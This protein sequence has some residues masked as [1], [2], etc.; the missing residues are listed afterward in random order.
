[1]ENMYILDAS[2]YLYRSYFAIR[3]MTNAKGESTN[4]LFGFIRSVLKLIKEFQP[5]HFVAVFDGPRN[6][7]KRTAIYADYKAHRREMP[8]DLYYQ[9]L[10]AQEFCQLMGIPEL[11]IPEVE[12]DDTMGSVAQW[13]TTIGAKSYLCTTDKDMCQLVNENVWMLNSFKDNQLL[14][15][16]GVY[17]QFGV[18]PH[19]MIDFLAITGDAS[20][21]VP[22]LTGF[23]PKTAAD[24]LQKFET[25]DQI[26]EQP[27]LVSGKKKQE[28]LINEREKVLLSR[29]LVTIDTS[30]PFPQDELFFR[31]KPPSFDALKE[32]YSKMNFSSLLRELDSSVQATSP[33]KPTPLQGEVNYHLVDDEAS[34]DQLIVLLSQQK[35]ICL[36]TETTNIHPLKARLVGVGLGIKSQEAWYIP[37]NGQLGMER[38]IQALK[39]L[40]ENPHIGYYG[41]HFK[42]DFHV[43]MNHDIEIKNICFDTML[44]SYLLNSHSRQ[45]SLD[46][47]SLELFDKVKTPIQELIGKGKS[48]ITMDLVPIQQVSDYCCEDVDYTVRLKETLEPLL[49]E[50]GLT[51]LLKD[52]EL[53]LLPVLA[54]MERHGIYVD[55]DYLQKLAVDLTIDVKALADEIYASVGEEFNLNSP[56]QLSQILFEKLAIRPP[57]KTATGHSTSAEVLE[58]LK[59]EYPIAAKILDYRS[60]EK[61][62]STYAES[63][64]ADVHPQTHRIHCNFNQSVTATGR[65]SCQDPNLQ[66]IP[67]RT[68]VGRKIRAAFKPQYPGWS[69]LAADYSQIELRLLAHLSE[70]PMLMTAFHSNEDVHTFT[71]AQIFNIPLAEVTREQRY[72]AKTVNFG[73]MYGQGA[74]GLAQLLSIDVKTASSFIQK[75]FQRYHKVKEFL[76][77]CK[78]LTRQTGKAVTLSGR[79]RLIPEIR[80]QNAGIRA[81]AERFAINAPIQG[82][83]A[84]LIK[85]AM[86]TIDRQLKERQKKAWLILQIHDELLFEVPD[87]ELDE[88]KELV[89][90]AMVGVIQLKVPLIVD[91]NI[92]KNWQEC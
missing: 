58:A 62:R 35:E 49:H 18:Y 19:Q 77:Q 63:L 57:K 79:E 36:D 48:Q 13:A 25:L 51:H 53:P 5:S 27:L 1:M 20:D 21:N 74:F 9:I 10:W 44:A 69:Y 22:G 66:N 37:T 56:K 42:Y 59:F 46:H 83:Q 39:P 52:L 34:L 92:G 7:I 38:V 28:T 50:R 82:T 86:L 78:E 30:V 81:A 31:L 80:S 84:D 16:Q 88:V 11:M 45:H 15:R 8:K 89:H 24:L 71:A 70:D 54:R 29:K 85:M 12:A 68:E 55:V 76:D 60:L 61:L 14:D 91:I 41:H 4:A 67:V 40:L 75:Y 64:P 32:F 6:A 90:E 23:G 17:H 73:T 43:L 2:G 47:L 65:L 72:Q 3:Q 33:A 26:L 87:D